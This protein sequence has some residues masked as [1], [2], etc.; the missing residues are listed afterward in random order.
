MSDERVA[1]TT[2]ANSGNGLAA[3]LEFARRGMCSV[4]TGRSRAKVAVVSEAAESLGLTV[5]TAILDVTDAQS[6][7]RVVRKYHPTVAVD[8][9]GFS[10][11]GAVEDVG[12]EEARAPLETGGRRSHATGTSGPSPHADGHDRTPLEESSQ[13]PCVMRPSN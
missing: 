12:D 6:C 9:A 11:T 2:G 1:L 3:T 8:N 13:S 7:E 4:G 5:E 10:V